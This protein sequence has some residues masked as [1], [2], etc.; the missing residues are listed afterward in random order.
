MLTAR[1]N[2]KADP[3]KLSPVSTWISPMTSIATATIR[4]KYFSIVEPNRVAKYATEKNKG[5]V[6]RMNANI[7]V[8]P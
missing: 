6:P 5:D 1:E 3:D 7:S 8:A 2:E 4:V